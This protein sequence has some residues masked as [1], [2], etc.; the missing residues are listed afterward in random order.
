MVSR[1]QIKHAIKVLTE[2]C[3]EDFAGVKDELEKSLNIA[4]EVLSGTDKKINALVE[5][6]GK[7]QSVFGFT[8]DHIKYLSV[9]H[10]SAVKKFIENWIGRQSDWRF[11]WCWLIANNYQYVYQSVKSTLVYVLSNHVSL[12]EIKYYTNE[13]TAKTKRA[14]ASMFRLKPLQHTGHIEDHHVPHNQ[15]G[16]LIALDLVPYYSL[17]QISNLIRSCKNV[18]RSGGQALI[19]FA[20]GDGDKEWKEF[21]DHKITYVNEEIIKKCAEDND[22]QSDIYH[23]DDMYSFVV[24]TK[25]GEKTSVKSHLTKITPL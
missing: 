11:P 19:H 22:L 1:R 16:A 23:I 12:K 18:L 5:D 8:E 7:A 17:E 13:K 24:L 15:I 21:I 10:P 3:D 14:N 2:A 4:K 6:Q 25:P 9:T 20:D